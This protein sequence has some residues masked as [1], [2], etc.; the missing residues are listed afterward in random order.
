M[1]SPHSDRST[2]RSS[3]ICLGHLCAGRL[4]S[5]DNSA[6]A[7]LQGRAAEDLL[8]PPA[9]AVR[10][11][12]ANDD[13]TT[14]GYTGDFDVSSNVDDVEKRRPKLADADLGSIDHIDSDGGVS[15]R[16]DFPKSD[17][18]S[19]SFSAGGITAAL[20]AGTS[21]LSSTIFG[22]SGA[23]FSAVEGTVTP[24]SANYSQTQGKAPAVTTVVHFNVEEDTMT[25]H[26][27]AL[28]RVARHVIAHS[29][30]DSAFYLV[31]VGQVRRM[32]EVS[33]RLE[34]EERGREEFPVACWGRPSDACDQLDESS[35]A[36]SYMKLANSLG[37][38]LP[39]RSWRVH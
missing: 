13:A 20:V 24:S 29:N 23:G 36:S 5:D 33:S 18:Q 1:A 26:L 16:A 10:F 6:T 4:N 12:I 31:D 27:S 11:S 25:A 32:H 34:E 14:Q 28:D 9:K 3:T 17:N 7:N 22:D 19:T 8:L 15:T 35:V 30:V 38:R 37:A 21:A 39:C 2:T